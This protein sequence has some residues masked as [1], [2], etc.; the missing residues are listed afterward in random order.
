MSDQNARKF[1][2]TFMVK[3]PSLPNTESNMGLV[4]PFDE[5]S[6]WE[7]VRRLRDDPMPTWA[8][9]MNVLFPREKSDLVVVEQAQKKQAVDSGSVFGL[10]F[11]MPEISVMALIWALVTLMAFGAALLANSVLNQGRIRPLEEIL[12]RSL[13]WVLAAWALWG[14]AALGKARFYERVLRR[15][16]GPSHPESD[17]RTETRPDPRD[18]LD[19]D[20]EPQ[21]LDSP[22]QPVQRF[23][24][25]LVDYARLHWVRASLAIFGAALCLGAYQLNGYNTFT[26][27]GVM[28]WIASIAVWLAVL[29]PSGWSA[30]EWWQRARAKSWSLIHFLSNLRE[31]EAQLWTAAA[32]TAIILLGVALRLNDFE[33]IP[34]DMTSDHVEKLLD[35]NRVYSG[36]WSIFFQNNGGREGMQMY[37]L[38][39][40]G[41]IMGEMSFETLKLMTVIEGVITLPL[42]YWLGRELVDKRLGLLAAALVTVSGWHLM[43][44]RLGL[45]IVLTP[46]FMALLTVYLVRGLR[47]NRRGDFL[48]AGVVLGFGLYAYQA[49][50]M[51]PVLVI[52]AGL[53]GLLAHGKKSPRA[54]WRTMGNFSTIVVISFVIFMP[55]LR[56]WVQ[57]PQDFWRRTGGRLFGD[58]VITVEDPETGA[59]YDKL[60][61]VQERWEAFTKNMGVLSANVRD[62]LLAF[63]ARGDMA[64]ITNV[65]NYPELDL[66]TGA[67][68]LLGVF[69]WLIHA[70]SRRGPAEWLVPIGFFIMLMPSALSLA[71]TVENPSATRIS[72]ALIFVY[73]MAAY[74]FSVLLGR[75]LGAFTGRLG[76]FFAVSAAVII[77][78]G[79]MGDMWDVYFVEYPDVYLKSHLP[80][81]HVGEVIR[82]F[83]NSFGS[84]ENAFMVAYPYWLDHRAIG[85]EAGAIGLGEDKMAWDNGLLEVE[86]WE[87]RR[88]DPD[89]A[90][91]FIYHRDDNMTHYYLMEEFPDGFMVYQRLPDPNKDYRLY[92]VPPLGAEEGAW[93]MPEGLTLAEVAQ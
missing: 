53:L 51:A 37:L 30:I 38:A 84:Y 77:V 8:A 64:W 15:L 13:I 85:I 61:N 4:V 12:P 69:A 68:F 21:K 62:A 43:L 79:A 2:F 54:F 93:N 46:L 67:L 88:V 10:A 20:P 55:L 6:V 86:Q 87:I 17:P 47:H 24:G 52:A 5:L 66:I 89:K 80:Y 29:A 11:S 57:Y 39:V 23:M 31:Y 41:G 59:R 36:Q 3:P 75:F 32:L 63:N 82:N 18:I 73:I 35:A 90:M 25:R 19:L 42:V 7:I 74:P 56:F 45:R 9:L 71:Y 76:R 22:P 27:F 28:I 49:M 92:I 14:A 83:A 26:V 65:P 50:R 72:G 33:H 48:K 81:N 34:P 91:M 40:L 78:I 70:L 58:D 60:A 1:A 44:S 16:R